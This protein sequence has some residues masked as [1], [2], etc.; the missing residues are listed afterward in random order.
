MRTTQ[1]KLFMDAKTKIALSQMRDHFMM[2]GRNGRWGTCASCPRD[3]MGNVYPEFCDYT[4]REDHRLEAIDL[5]KMWEI[6]Y[7]K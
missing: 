1:M 4:E 7:E 6:L 5:A 3:S 2:F